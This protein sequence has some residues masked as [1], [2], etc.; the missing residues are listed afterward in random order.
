[1]NQL[2]KLTPAE[3]LLAVHGSA[4]HLNDLLKYTLMDLIFRQVLELETTTREYN[5]NEPPRIYQYVVP[6]RNYDTWT[7]KLHETVFLS[8]FRTNSDQKILFKNMVSIGYQNAKSKRTYHS[9]VL[10][11]SGLQ[12]AFETTFLQKIFGGFDYT[13]SG[14]QLKKTIADEFTALEEIVASY[15]KTQD[16][17]I[18]ES[19]RAIGGNIFLVRGLDIA[20]AQE[21]DKELSEEMK[22]TS[23]D[24]SG[25]GGTGCWTTFDTS[26]CSSSS[27]HS[28]CSSHGDSGCSSSGCSG[29][30]GCGGGD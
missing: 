9:Y 23:T 27:G 8:T 19:L 18:L 30:G 10:R 17:N 5:K 3:T 24:M 14:I 15:R 4:T 7:D 11:N 20:L 6:G 21:I 13:R 2:T 1:M 16:K 25:C 22:R 29:C 12:G 26:G 28:G